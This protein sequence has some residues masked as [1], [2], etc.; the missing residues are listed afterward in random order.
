MSDAREAIDWDRTYA[1]LEAARRALDASGHLPPDEV[2]RV[3]RA[4]AQALARPVEEAPTPAEVLDCLV[5]SLAGERYG[6][7]MPHVLEVLPLRE[8]V[9]VPGTPSF[10]L[11]VVNHR[12]RI[13]TVLDLRRLFDLAGQE[14]AERSRVVAVEAGGM[15]FGV[16]AEAVMGTVSVGAHEVAPPPV[17]LT[18]DRQAFL[19]GVTGE[20]VAIL[21]L[22]TLARDPRI[23]VNDEVG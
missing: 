19:R 11:G 7:E 18:G 22:E 14:V 2:T 4:R 5:F 12:G 3:L 16:Y 1:R 8:P 9:P 17:I 15:T 20:M 13:L 6:I 21:D 23:T 10:V